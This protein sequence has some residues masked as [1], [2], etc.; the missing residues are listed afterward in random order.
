M[1][2]SADEVRRLAL[3]LPQ[4]LEADHHGTPSFRVAGKIFATL[5]YPDSSRAMVK[6]KP[7]QQAE[8]VHDYPEAFSPS[9]GAW[10]RQGSTS[11]HLAK[12]RKAEVQRALQAALQNAEVASLKSKRKR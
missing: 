11:V 9:A 4:A 1:P 3:A 10:G 2:V 6:L 12:A 8:F 7:E 5:N